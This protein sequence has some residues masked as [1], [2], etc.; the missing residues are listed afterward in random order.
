M[1]IV[2]PCG[3]SLLELDIAKRGLG[4]GFQF[5]YPPTGSPPRVLKISR[6]LR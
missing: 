6:L 4:L 1:E 3:A 2:D 5:P